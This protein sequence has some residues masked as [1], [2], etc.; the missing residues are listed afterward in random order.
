MILPEMELS[1]QVCQLLDYNHFYYFHVPSEGRRTPWEQRAF[2]SNGGKAGVPDLVIVLQHGRV[3]WVEL[4]TP[5]GRQSTHQK[6]FQ[7][8]V[9]RRGHKYEIWRTIADAQ[10]FCLE[11]GGMR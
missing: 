2:K 4:K 3:H 8:I 7:E 6:L 9:E 1:K 11:Y 5:T 10:A